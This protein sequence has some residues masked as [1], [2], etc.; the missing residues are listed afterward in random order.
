MLIAFNRINLHASKYIYETLKYN[1]FWLKCLSPHVFS[2][3]GVNVMYICMI[4]IRV[5][6]NTILFYFILLLSMYLCLKS[7]RDKFNMTTI[8]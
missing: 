8:S 4:N 7:I 3:C 1:I 5:I 2:I 6:V